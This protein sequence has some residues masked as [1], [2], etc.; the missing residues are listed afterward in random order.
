MTACSGTSRWSPSVGRKGWRSPA[1]AP[2]AIKIR[3]GSS[4]RM[5]RWSAVLSVTAGSK[6]WRR[7]RLWPAACRRP[8]AYQFIPAILQTAAK[9]PD[10]RPAYQALPPAGD[11]C[12]REYWR[13]PPSMTRTR[14]SCADC[15]RS[16]IR[17]V[18]IA[19]I[20]AAQA[21]LGKRVDR[22][23][24]T[25]RVNRSLGSTI[26]ASRSALGCPRRCDPGA[27]QNATSR[28]LH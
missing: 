3:P 26:Y 28:P 5:A 7:R 18:L 17:F 13:M 12:R 14:T 20:R 15:S 2:T 8:P 23:G 19:E 1:R 21:Q 9:D 11:P 24:W 4:R 6:V 16:R 25:G 22:R 10:R 27:H